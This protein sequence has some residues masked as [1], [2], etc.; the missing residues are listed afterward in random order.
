[1]NTFQQPQ[2]LKIPL[3][4]GDVVYTPDWL[5][6]DMLEFFQPSGEILDPCRGKGA[7]W[8]KIPGCL[9]CEISEGV[10]FYSWTRR[11]DWAIGNPP[12]RQFVKWMFHSFEIA[13]NILYLFPADK[14]Y[15]SMR[16]L[17]AL[18]RWGDLRHMRIYGTGNSI[19]F[20]V[21]F[22]VAALHFQRGYFGPMYKSFYDE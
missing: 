3:D 7:F 22:A 1:M 15:I 8:E 11:I 6:Y 17:N 21:G 18:R 12:Y 14:P 9:W 20:P 13:E 16:F 10:D 4:P 5:V 2:L 19:G